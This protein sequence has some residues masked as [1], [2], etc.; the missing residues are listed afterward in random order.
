MIDCRDDLRD[1]RIRRPHERPML[2]RAELHDVLGVIG[3]AYPQRM[4]GVPARRIERGAEPA[5]GHPVP[6]RVVG[7]GEV[8]RPFYRLEPR[9]VRTAAVQQQPVSVRVLHVG[10]A[11]R[12]IEPASHAAVLTQPLAQG[13]PA[14]R[15]ARR[16]AKPFAERRRSHRDRHEAVALVERDGVAVQ[17]VRTRKAPGRER[18]GVHP[19]RGGED[20]AVVGVPARGRCE[21]VQVRSECFVHVVAAQAVDHDED[22]AALGGV[23]VADHRRDQKKRD[24]VSWT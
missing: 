19:G 15:A 3:L 21:P 17:A 18:G 11:G 1:V 5:G 9:L 4:Q 20:R 12:G 6:G 16:A 2:V 7:D 13:G 14:K 8:L 22:G 23:A 24:N 10:R